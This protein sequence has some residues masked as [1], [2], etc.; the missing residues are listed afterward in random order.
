[1]P[2]TQVPV[3]LLHWILA[4]LPIVALLVFLVPLK[5]RA[6]EAGPM[7]MFTAAI[8]AL[9]A[10]R[11]PWDT[12]AVAGAKGVW[13]AIFILYVIWPALLLYQITKQAGAYDALRQGIAKFSR[14]DLFIILAL[15]WVFA[16]FLQGI[17]G[18]GAPVAVVVPLLIAMGVKPIQAVAMGVVAHAW[19]RFFGTLGVG[20]LATL[21]V[22]NLE[23]VV[24]A[25]YESALLILIPTY[26]G[27][28][29]VVWLYGKGPAVRHAW[30]L[31]LILGTILGV[32]QLLVALISP[33]LSTFLAAAVAMLALYP[34]SRWKRYGEPI[35]REEIPERPGMVERPVSEQKEAAPVMSLSMSFLPYVVL[36]AVTLG[37]LLIPALNAIMRQLQVGLPFPAV[38]TGFGIQNAAV[39]RYAPITVF[40]HPGMML[41]ITSIIVWIV[42]S[43]GGYYGAWAERHKPESIWSALLIDAVPASV[44]VI[45]FLVTSR[46]LDHSGQVLTLAYGMAAVSPPLVYAGIASVI[47]ALGA[48]MTS[49]STASNVLFGGVQSSVAQLHGMSGETII[50]AQAGGSAYGNAIAPANI[51]LGT[52]VAGVKGQEGA[53][54]RTT[55]PWTILVAVLTGLATIALVIAR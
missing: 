55:M 50:A 41:L 11:T 27:G 25:A 54:L 48:F 7:A 45:A 53:V 49:S 20:W 8:V 47:G 15:A 51:V 29:L 34:L 1:M 9:L 37:V 31:V 22:A 13:D 26:L 28:L 40:T 33:E 6:P 42:Y 17:A 36:T 24:R 16:S 46:I 43:A 38:E 21:R 39:A 4:V 19:A 14:N 18:F 44:P 2:A 12:L 3:D 5:W 30:P 35:P 10:F 32:G 23:D 52:S